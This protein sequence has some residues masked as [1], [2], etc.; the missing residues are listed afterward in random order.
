MWV[1][2]I[3]WVY[4]LA[5]CSRVCVCVAVL[6]VSFYISVLETE[7]SNRAIIGLFS[8]CVAVELQNLLLFKPQTCTCTC[9]CLCVFLSRRLSLYLKVYL[10]ISFWHSWAVF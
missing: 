5:S 2:S 1:V 8:G 3:I 4:G 6:G 10:F 9:V 7:M